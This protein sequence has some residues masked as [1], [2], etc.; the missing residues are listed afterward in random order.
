MD[1]EI[2][3]V[4]IRALATSP[5][6]TRPKKIMSD[7]SRSFHQYTYIGLNSFKYSSASDIKE[8]T[9]SFIERN[10]FS[11]QGLV[12]NIMNIDKQM[13]LSIKELSSLIH[14]PNSKFNKNPRIKWQN[15]KL[16]SAPDNLSDEGILL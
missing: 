8:F 2:F 10:F 13:I 14:F 12:K 6:S 11:E 5:D 4:R 16:V 1:D 3:G 7:L 15:Y 9:K